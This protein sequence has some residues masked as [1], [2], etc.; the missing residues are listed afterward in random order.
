MPIYK[1]RLAR[2]DDPT[3]VKPNDG[4]Q[5]LLDSAEKSETLQNIVNSQLRISMAAIHTT[6]MNLTQATFDLLA[7]PEYIQ[8]LRQEVVD[9]LAEEGGW[10]K[11]AL[12]KMKK[13]DSF[14]KESQRLSPPG[15]S[16]P[17]L[18]PTLNFS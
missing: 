5:W 9:V 6:A 7:H 1:E 13:A 15:L 16:E 14:I 2:R 8:D 18:F 10:T 3:F 12:S 17:T 4:I 11:Q